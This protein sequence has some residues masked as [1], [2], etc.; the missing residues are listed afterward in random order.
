MI[1]DVK[2]TCTKDSA[3][4]NTINF[5]IGEFPNVLRGNLPEN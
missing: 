2:K 3:K 5:T 1:N 4:M